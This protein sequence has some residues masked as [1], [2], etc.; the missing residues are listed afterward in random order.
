VQRALLQELSEGP[1]TVTDLARSVY[2][3]EYDDGQG[4]YD[5][6]YHPWPVTNGEMASASRA[7]HS[8][9]QR[10]LVEVEPG[11]SRDP[12]TGHGDGRLV[13]ISVK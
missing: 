4:S 9:A 10:G 7:I 2:H 8:L 3:P 1:M 12:V 11:R 6:N 5:W 13:W